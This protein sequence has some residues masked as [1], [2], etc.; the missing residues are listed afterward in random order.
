M[1]LKR[2]EREEAEKVDDVARE[3]QRRQMG[4]EM[5]K[6]KEQLEM[7]Q[8]KREAMLRK[9]EKADFARER[10][11]LREELARDKAERASGKGKLSSRLGVE[12]Y[13]PDGIQ[14]DVATGD[15]HHP[16]TMEEPTPKS[17]KKGDPTKMEEYIKKVSSYRAGGDG[18]NCLRILIL[19][20]GN[21][22]DNP[23]EEKY[24][25]IKMDNKTYRTKV[26]P[27]IGAKDILL[28]CGFAPPEGGGDML[29]LPNE[30]M[31]LHLLSE[32]KAKLEAA[33]E[34]FNK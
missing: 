17:K 20:V 22:V 32:T 2:A 4:K 23:T 16:T 29:V 28:A 14:Y 13:K 25:T 27:F 10:E 33:Y 19:Y 5:A 12:G 26:K 9:K 21:V 1:K 24:K 3:I 30:H 8:R 11:R 34:A 15:G 18:G 7:E 6:T 31:D